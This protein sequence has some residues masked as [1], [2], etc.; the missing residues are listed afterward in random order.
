[1]NAY[2]C[3]Y[4]LINLFN[5]DKLATATNLEENFPDPT[6]RLLVILI[7]GLR[8]D[9]VA[10]HLEEKNSEFGFK[11]LQRNGAYLERF[12]PVFPAE[13]YPNIYSLFTGRHPVDHGVVL[14]TSFNHHT[15]T[16]GEPIRLQAEGLWET[17]AKQNKGVHLYHL[18]TC[19]G[20]LNAGGDNSW[21]CEPYNPNLMNPVDLNF[22]I[23]RAV[24]G[25][26]NGSANLAVVYYDE[27]DR[28]G[29]RYGP[30]SNELV[31]K[32]WVYLDH[33]MDH[34]LNIVESIPNLNLIVTSDHGMAPVSRKAYVDR[35]FKGS[36][37]SRV[38][39][40]GSTMWLWPKPKF[41]ERVYNRLFS[42]QNKDNFIVYNSSTIPVHWE[43]TSGSKL[44]PPILLIAAPN[45]IFNSTVW[46][47]NMS[48][49]NLHEPK[50][51]HGYDPELPDMHIPLFI[52]GP[53]SNPGVQLN[54][55]K[56][57][58]SI[59][60]HSLMAHLASIHLPDYQSLNFFRSLLRNYEDEQ[61]SVLSH[62]YWLNKSSFSSFLNK[63]RFIP[64][65]LIITAVLACFFIVIVSLMILLYMRCRM[66]MITAQVACQDELNKELVKSEVL[67]DA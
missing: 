56:E 62:L 64:T 53:K 14:P 18:P 6:S 3:L 4:I 49:Y 33:V 57:I 26:R 60:I 34:A 63:D 67:S 16:D 1:M 61:A 41:E 54:Y 22:T 19:S 52:Y 32:H 59:H 13:C 28:I 45:Y 30:L 24:S 29:H 37:L 2:I 31:H 27:L 47:L 12:A 7:D 9:V 42:Q 39:N 8:W 20:D 66:S 40:R 44:F 23:Q 5:V 65:F 11:R 51:M 21:F 55:T 25:L 46:P 48:H 43:V 50:G 58:R 35:L 10:R 15:T 36:E 38:L 17:G